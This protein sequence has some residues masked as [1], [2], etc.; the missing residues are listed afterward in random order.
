MRRE[1]LWD[2]LFHATQ[3]ASRMKRELRG[4]NTSLC[5]LGLRQEPCIAKADG[6]RLPGEHSRG[7]S[8]PGSEWLVAQQLAWA[9]PQENEVAKEQD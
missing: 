6:R 2:R 9:K 5:H 3:I 4:Q 7:R 8:Q 1:D